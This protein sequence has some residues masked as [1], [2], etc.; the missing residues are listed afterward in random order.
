MI[1][2]D[3]FNEHSLQRSDAIADAAKK[4]DWDKLLRLLGNESPDINS[5]RIGGTAWYAPLH[6]SAHGGAPIEVVERLLELGAWRALRTAKHELAVDIARRRKH[7][8]LVKLLTPRAMRKVDPR[9]LR[10][11]QVNFH[12]VIH[13]RID[14]IDGIAKKL[15]LPELGPVTEYTSARFVFTVP[16]MYGGFGYWLAKGRKKPTLITESWCRV[17]EGSGQRHEVTADG[18]KLVAEGFV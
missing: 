9:L 10:R 6:Q 17:S 13:G 1:R 11:M 8:H 7:L 14:A 15:R 12:E 2:R 3:L 5:S 18:A 16:G 4:Y